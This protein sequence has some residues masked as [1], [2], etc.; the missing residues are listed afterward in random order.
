MDKVKEN[1]KYDFN[2]MIQKSWTF[3]K[4]TK[5]ERETWEHIITSEPLKKALKGGY[6]SRWQILQIVYS[7]FLAGVGYNGA[8][9]RENKE[10]PF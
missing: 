1:A 6:D 5:S 3:D 2:D 10:K 4:L 9:W 8:N 7:S